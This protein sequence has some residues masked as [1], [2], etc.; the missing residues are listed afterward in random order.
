VLDKQPPS[1]PS[2]LVG[3]ISNGALTLSWHASTDNVGVSR[4]EVFLDGKAVVGVAADTTRATLRA[5]E[6]HGSSVYTVSAF[7]AAGNQSSPSGSVT[8]RPRPYPKSAPKNVPR[9]TWQ[10]L[11]WQLH[12]KGARPKAAPK[13]VPAWYAAWKRWRQAP[14]QLVS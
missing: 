6:A 10:L 12:H 13:H 5:F 14:F 11:A 1:A 8:A 7:D 9:W 3:A 4:Y 2:G